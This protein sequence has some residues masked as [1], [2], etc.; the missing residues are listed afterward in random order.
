MGAID[1]QRRRLLAAAIAATAAGAL[2]ARAEPVPARR[3][4]DGT[5]LPAIGL[6]TWRAFD[7]GAG[8]PGLEDA[9]AALAAFVGGG[10]RVLDTS[11]M[12]GAAETV[13]GELQSDGGLRGRLYLATKIWTRGEEA[14]VAQLAESQ[15]RLRTAHLDLVQVHNLL[16][17]EAHLRSLRGARDDGRVRHI[18]ITHYTAA[19]HDAL[20]DWMAREPIDVVQVNYSLMEPEADRRLLDAAAARGVGVLVNRPLGEGGLIRRTRGQPLPP[21]TVERGVGSWAQ[22]CL[23]W[24]LGHPAVTC[25]LVGTRN[26]AHVRDNLAAAIGWIPDAAERERMRT[27]LAALPG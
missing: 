14:G 23:K 27:D 17:V 11:P 19:A 21:W 4:R 15:R 8:E 18:G 12:Y 2:P 20:V 5:P 10:G 6:G 24:V 22:F 25:A 16:G 26:P 9:R 13:V 7:I 1:H 3:L